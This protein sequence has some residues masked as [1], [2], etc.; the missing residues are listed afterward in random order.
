MVKGCHL[1]V[2]VIGAGAS[3]LY[4]SYCLG[5]SGVSTCLFESL[6]CLGGQASAFY[7]DKKVYGVPGGDGLTGAEFIAK[8]SKQAFSFSSSSFVNAK[9][10]SIQKSGDLFELYA[11]DR[12]LIATSKYVILACGVGEMAPVVPADISGLENFKNTCYIQYYCLRM[13][14]YKG[15]TVIIAGGGDSAADFALNI[16]V[17]S[18]R[19]ILVHRGQ[20]LS[21]DNYK[22]EKLLD[23][24]KK[25]KLRI[26]LNKQILSMNSE[27][28]CQYISIKDKLN[29][30]LLNIASDY[31]V[32]CY[33]FTA[34]KSVISGL[35]LKTHQ[36]LIEV[37][38]DNMQTSVDGCFAIGDCVYYANK[39]KN[40]V[41]CFFESDRVARYIAKVAAGE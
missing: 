39:K 29:E 22:L 37:N 3:G 26:L 7:P 17:V 2:S 4:A 11:P 16:G 31:I 30:S 35:D 41:S 33:G 25:G 15:K 18:D 8:L 28:S 5:M 13:D 21:C 12:E 10:V 9:I 1:D 24:E 40:F 34:K 36:G 19:I 38:I 32:F 20:K 27:S 14:M 6:G 23:L